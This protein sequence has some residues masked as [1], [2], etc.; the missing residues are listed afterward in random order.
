MNIREFSRRYAA[1]DNHIALLQTLLT[2]LAYFLFLWAAI[3][4]AGI[5]Y[6]VIP[7][8]FGAGISAVRLYMLQHDCGHGSFFTTRR[9]NDLAG[10]LMSPFTL[11]PYRAT[12][13]NHNQHHAHIGDLERRDST[14]IYTMTLAEY[15]A[16]PWWKRAGYRIYRNPVTLFLVGPT[17]LYVVLYRFPRN[18]VKTGVWDAVL[19]NVL[20]GAFIAILYWVAG[21]T[22][23]WVLLGSV[24][25]GVS[26]G[27]II[28]Y[29]QHNFEDI[30]WQRA[31]EL[32]FETAALR[33]SAVLDFGWL[34]D[35][36]TANIAYHDLHHLNSNIP[37][38]RLKQCHQALGPA[39][40]SKRIGYREALGCLRWKLWDEEQS[41]MVGFPRL[42]A[43]IRQ[44]A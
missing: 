39:L 4:F 40:N 8:M 19:N 29:V 32:E 10:T 44:P 17:L 37:S 22:G 5:W 24:F 15:R 14:E 26:F 41:R 30:Y 23:L 31:P 2:L 12:K 35:L 3:W 25:M 27:A 36:A 13:Y 20:I 33:G 43:R 7:L 18:A 11:T 21:S 9:L 1:R 16:A 28:P 38:Y 6:A 42:G 34:F